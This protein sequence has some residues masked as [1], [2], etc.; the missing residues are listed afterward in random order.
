MKFDFAIGNPPYQEENESNGRKPPIYHLFMEQT[1]QIANAVELITPARFL[2]EAGQTPKKWNQKMLNDEHFKVLLYESDGSR[3]FPNTDIKGGVAITLRDE[4]RDF[5]KIQVF[6]AF[7]ELNGILKKISQYECDTL[8]LDSMVSSRGYY[9]LTDRFFIDYPDAPNKLGTGTGNMIVSNIFDKLPEVFLDKC[10]TDSKKYIRI[11]GRTNNERVYRYIK[12]VYVQ[13]NE[14]IDTFN[15]LLPKSNGSGAFGETLSSPLVGKPNEAATDTFI[16]IGT[17]ETEYEA[18]SMLKYLKSKFARA[19]LSIKKV[20]QDN[21]KS[22][23]KII[24]VQ[25]FSSG[26]DINWTTDISC[27]DQQLYRKYNFSEKE[28]D[29]IETN[30]KEMD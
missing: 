29:F 22:V 11:L 17:F 15:V 14:Y 10:P 20:T 28:I 1:Y 30:V 24:P 18:E 9:R 23:W 21:P 8:R 12:R 16:N 19:L 13:H 6:T 27:I 5:G 7:D 4:K 2:F 25:D 26:S 3:I